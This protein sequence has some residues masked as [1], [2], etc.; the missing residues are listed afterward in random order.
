[1]ST[2]WF[3]YDSNGQ[4]QGPVSGGELKGLAKTG[5]IIPGTMVEAESGKIVPAVKI[6][7]LTFGE[8]TQSEPSP[9]TASMPAVA[10]NPFTAAM[11]IKPNPFSPVPTISHNDNKQTSASIYFYIDADGNR[12]GPWNKQHLR[13]LEACGLIGLNTPIET[14][15]GQAGRAREFP[16]LLLGKKPK[17]SFNSLALTFI[18]LGFFMLAVIGIGISNSGGGR[19]SDGKNTVTAAAEFV[20]HVVRNENNIYDWSRSEGQKFMDETY[21]S[22]AS[23]LGEERNGQIHPKPAFKDTYELMCLVGS[24]ADEVRMPDTHGKFPTPRDQFRRELRELIPRAT[25]EIER[26]G[27]RVSGR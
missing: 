26:A 16:D 12:R 18:G 2:T 17:S 4:K 7:G 27:G 22:L 3:Y 15:T 13:E 19:S 24:R 23:V 1:M 21:W 6:K 25:A 14:S 11:S 20:E 8:A 5:K 9:F 10:D